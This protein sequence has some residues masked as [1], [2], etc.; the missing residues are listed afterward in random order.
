MIDATACFCAAAESI[1]TR[2]V[3]NIVADRNAGAHAQRGQD[4]PK[5][6]IRPVVAQPRVKRVNPVK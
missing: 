6:P 3:A 2:Y 5:T 1:G 4:L